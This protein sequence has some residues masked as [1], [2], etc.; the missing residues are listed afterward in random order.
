LFL[1]KEIE[2]RI[3]TREDSDERE[4]EQTRGRRIREHI[5]EEARRESK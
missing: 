5:T 1:L 3:R 4:K 2:E